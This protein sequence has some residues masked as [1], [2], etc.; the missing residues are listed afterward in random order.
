MAQ[1]IFLGRTKRDWSCG[2]LLPP[3]RNVQKSSL[4]RGGGEAAHKVAAG[5][6]RG[7]SSFARA[8]G[9]GLGALAKGAGAATKGTSSALA[10]KKSS[11]STRS[12]SRPSGIPFTHRL[13]N[14]LSRHS[15][16]G[17][18]K[19]YSRIE[20]K[21]AQGNPK[22]QKYVARQVALAKKGDKKALARA[23]AMK[24]TRMVRL[25]SKTA[26]DRRCLSQG[27]KLAKGVLKKNPKSIRQY[28]QLQ[29]AA[30]KGNPHA[31]K[32]LAGAGLSAAVLATVA[33]GR[34]TFPKKNIS[35]Q[36]AALAK[37]VDESRRK[38][39]AGK[40]TKEEAEAGARAAK[41]LGD[42]QAE[43]YLSQAAQK[44]SPVPPTAKP[45]AKPADKQ[46][47]EPDQEREAAQ[48]SSPGPAMEEPSPEAEESVPG[49]GAAPSPSEIQALYTLLWTACAHQL[50]Q[51]DQAS[52]LRT[53]SLI[54]YET[55][56]KL[57]A[58]KELAK[59][60]LPTTR[61]AGDPVPS[62][63]R[64]HRDEICLDMSDGDESGAQSED[65]P[66]GRT[67]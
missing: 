24:L 33:T 34:V 18:L 62:L 20:K 29:A 49:E 53:K 15:R 10:S 58:K 23:Q 8:M 60:G 28:R 32:I 50:V 46:K 43:A 19:R 38:A 37:K 65:L 14:A 30:G 47:Q 12:S 16:K 17:E 67:I 11:R 64:P 22:Y 2:S 35:K 40:I 7:I 6:G 27:N 25:N 45:G 13:S 51:Q 66:G 61:L 21:S 3:G 31:K 4:G 54:T 59:Q 56:S 26:A 44:A 57:W 36:K 1:D 52:H 39:R 42:K 48:A 63:G 9:K 55:L 41:Q 5:A